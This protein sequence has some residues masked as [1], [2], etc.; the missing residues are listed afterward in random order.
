MLKSYRTV[1]L[2]S[3]L[4]LL[5]GV[6]SGQD[7]DFTS[8]RAKNAARE[9]QRDY[10]RASDEF[11]KQLNKSRKEFINA[12][13]IAESTATR[14]KDLKEAVRIRLTWSKLAKEM[15]NS[16]VKVKPKRSLTESVPDTKWLTS[17][18]D[19]WALFRDGTATAS[20]SGGKTIR[21]GRWFKADVSTICIEFQGFYVMVFHDDFSKA[22]ILGNNT[23]ILARR[24]K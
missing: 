23:K 2:L 24:V 16:K 4:C 22:T 11:N 6:V 20:I 5:A 13:K 7:Y 3:F 19:V 8:S 17:G 18:K 9:Y 1:S 12:L 10:D 14:N 15:Q 21:S